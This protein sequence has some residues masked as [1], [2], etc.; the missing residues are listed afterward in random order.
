MV[1]KQNVRKGNLGPILDAK[2]DM[3]KKALMEVWT[4]WIFV[5]LDVSFFRQE[6]PFY[7]LIPGSDT[8]SIPKNGF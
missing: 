8:E 4:E 2:I 1:L 7:R 6:P 3:S 5:Y